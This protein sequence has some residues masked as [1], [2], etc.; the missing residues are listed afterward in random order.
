MLARQ[1][2]SSSQAIM[3]MQWSANRYR[4]DSGIVKDCV[5]IRNGRRA[6]VESLKLGKA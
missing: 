5:A 6:G 1:K 2:G 4:V 3:G